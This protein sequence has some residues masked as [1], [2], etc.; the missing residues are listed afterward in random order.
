MENDITEEERKKKGYDIDEVALR[1]RE[2]RKGRKRFLISSIIVFCF[3]ILVTIVSSLFFSKDLAFI[4]F[5][6]G[7][8]SSLYLLFK[9]LGIM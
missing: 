4:A 2:L 1:D 3:T 5:I 7:G 6:I 9:Y 8:L